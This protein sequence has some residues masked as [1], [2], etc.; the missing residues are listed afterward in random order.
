MDTM[1]FKT[2]VSLVYIYL[3]WHPLS[4]YYGNRVLGTV[5]VRPDVSYSIVGPLPVGIAGLL[6]SYH[7]S[8]TRNGKR[9]SNALRRSYKSNRYDRDLFFRKGIYL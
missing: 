2:S 4:T 5:W 9:T 3:T 8:K 1:I 6:K 7:Q